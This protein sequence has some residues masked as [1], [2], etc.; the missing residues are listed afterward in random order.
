ML[1]CHRFSHSNDKDVVPVC[2][3]FSDGKY[4]LL[5]KDSSVVVFRMCLP[6]AFS[7]A[8]R[9]G[10]MGDLPSRNSLWCEPHDEWAESS[11]WRL[12]HVHCITGLLSSMTTHVPEDPK[13]T[14]LTF[15]ILRGFLF[16][17]CFL[18]CAPLMTDR[19]GA[20]GEGLSTFTAPRALLSSM[21]PL[22]LQEV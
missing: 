3:T 16:C 4:L 22:V 18:H 14:S 9:G 1:T 7:D 10:P 2:Y 6:E 11:G 21:N 19:R 13:T 17:F 5:A 20:A 12:S 8:D 15:F